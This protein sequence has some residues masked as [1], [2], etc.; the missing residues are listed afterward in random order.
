MRASKSILLREHKPNL[1]RILLIDHDDARRATR[2]LLLQQEGY[3]VVT[4][5]NYDT[6]EG[7]IR[8]A[9]FDLVIVE[10]DDIKEAVLAYSERLRGTQPQLP[11]LVLSD[12]GL[13]LPKEVLLAHFA[14]SFP[15]PVEVLAK[16]AAMF[17]ESTHRREQ[18]T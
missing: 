1:K 13:F 2:V 7:R 12:Q 11:I 8:E 6:V 10:T 5:D 4:A 16:I 18:S 14:T 9:A 15:S 17:L 3:E